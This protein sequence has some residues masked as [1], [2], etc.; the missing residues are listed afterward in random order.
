MNRTEL[1]KSRVSEEYY[2]RYILPNIKKKHEELN[3]VR[4]EMNEDQ[5]YFVT[6]AQTKHLLGLL[7]RIRAEAGN[8]GYYWNGT[9]YTYDT[10]NVLIPVRYYKKGG[11]EVNIEL[12]ADQIR[13]ELR[14]RE[15]MLDRSN[16]RKAIRVHHRRLKAWEAKQDKGRN[17]KRNKA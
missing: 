10:E 12:N 4:A 7:K 3:K 17:N 16:T 13:T 9:P 5:I 15:D 2:N 1:L 6:T 11:I 14:N 8:T